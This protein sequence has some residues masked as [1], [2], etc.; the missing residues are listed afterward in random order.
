MER[1]NVKDTKIVMCQ[2][3]R[4]EGTEVIHFWTIRKAQSHHI[5]GIYEQISQTYYWL[6]RKICKDT[7]SSAEVTHA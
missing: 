1:V 7:V 6:I 2:W 5:L 3:V 4:F